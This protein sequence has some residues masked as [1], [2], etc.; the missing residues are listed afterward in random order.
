MNFLIDGNVRLR[1][2]VDGEVCPRRALEVDETADVIILVEL[3]EGALDFLARQ[4][5]RGESNR[6]PVA[7]CDR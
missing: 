2:S 6:L 5:E 3:T 4:S 1:E 7:A